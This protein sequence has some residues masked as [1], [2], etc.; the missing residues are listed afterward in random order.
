M[1]EIVV[2]VVM[3]IIMMTMTGVVYRHFIM[4]S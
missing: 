3:M 4:K 1:I 2:V